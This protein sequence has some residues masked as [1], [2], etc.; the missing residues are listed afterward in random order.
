MNRRLASARHGVASAQRRSLFAPHICAR[1]KTVL[2]S[3]TVSK[4]IKTVSKL[5]ET[6]IY[7]ENDTIMFYEL[8][9]MF[10]KD[11]VVLNGL[12]QIILEEKKHAKE[13]KEMMSSLPDENI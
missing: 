2:I 10:I 13:L 1:A 9:K 4:K 8:L 6:F 12:K 7:F 11:E 3:K 5:L